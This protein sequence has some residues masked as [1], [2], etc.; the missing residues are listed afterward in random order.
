[1]HLQ[2]NALTKAFGERAVLDSVALTLDSGIYALTGPSGCGKTTLA[3]ILCGLEEKDS[4]SITPQSYKASFMFQEPRLF[5]WLDVLS[6]VEK[7]TGCDTKRATELLEALELGD[8][9]RKHPYELSVGMQRRVA[10]ARTL[11]PRD[12]DLYVFDEPLAGLDEERKRT[13]CRLIKENVPPDSV[14]IIISHEL[15]EVSEISDC[16]LKFADGKIFK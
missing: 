15:S 1:M 3:R 9:L 10:I 6:N 13:V 14:V 8:D 11:A 5:P 4:G 7:V 16:V 12:A 2:I